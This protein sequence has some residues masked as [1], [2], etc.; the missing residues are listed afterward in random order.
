MEDNY[1]TITHVELERNILV[2]LEWPIQGMESTVLSLAKRIILEPD[3]MTCFLEVQNIPARLV[4]IPTRTSFIN[5]FQTVSHEELADAIR[6]DGAFPRDEHS[7]KI[8]IPSGS[9]SCSKLS[10][11]IAKRTSPKTNTE[12]I[13]FMPPDFNSAVTPL[14]VQVAPCEH[15]CTNCH[16]TIV[17]TNSFWSVVQGR[18]FHSFG[19]IIFKDMMKTLGG[20]TIKGSGSGSKRF[21]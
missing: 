14:Y 10:V 1:A 20:L 18:T 9:Q 8:D 5:I 3:D 15:S 17:L 4:R 16:A 7:V 19:T 12:S 11:A 13:G 21:I 6:C 2:P